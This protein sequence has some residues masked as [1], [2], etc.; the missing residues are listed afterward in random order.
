MS[1]N[2][3]KIIKLGG[4]LLTDKDKPFSL[5]RKVVKKC[6]YQIIQSNEKIILIHGG[7]SFGHPLAKKFK[8][9]DGFNPE[10]KDQC[11][12]LAKT[13]Q[14]MVEF[15]SFIVK[16]FINNGVPAISIDPSSIFLKNGNITSSKLI[17]KIEL[18][19]KL[20][21][22]PI[23]YGDIIFD[24][25][26]SFSIISGDEIIVE[27]CDNIKNYKIEKVIFAMDQDG[28]Y[29]ESD[30]NSPTL[31]TSVNSSELQGLKL[32]KFVDKIDVTGG[33]EEKI[34]KIKQIIGLKIPVQL[35]NGLKDDY[36]F[37]SLK[38]NYIPS[39]IIK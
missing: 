35:I 37:K 20:E 36:I 24:T 14:A 6:I 25:K 39:T 2:N 4:S 23:L 26:K 11:L 8:I 5:R 19:L 16:E 38:N 7:G 29:I 3:I 31:L 18:L 30:E 1:N 13:H 27:I 21:I 34:N 10:I 32:A 22:V 33:I 9:V 15:N 12:G 17:Y 28:I